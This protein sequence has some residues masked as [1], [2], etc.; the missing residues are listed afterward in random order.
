MDLSNDASSL[1]DNAENGNTD[2]VREL[3][4]HKADVH[5]CGPNWDGGKPD[6]ALRWAARNGHTDTVRVLL[7]EGNACVAFLADDFIRKYLHADSCDSVALCMRIGTHILCSLDT[8]CRHTFSMKNYTLKRK[9]YTTL[10][11]QASGTC[12]CRDLCELVLM[13]V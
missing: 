5:S 8:I 1:C 2:T 9:L 6:A 7:V 3:L 4:A 13:Y 11:E 10:L 12:C